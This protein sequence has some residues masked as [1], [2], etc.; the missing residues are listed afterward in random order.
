M[1]EPMQAP[2]AHFASSWHLSV[3]VQGVSLASF[4]NVH[5]PVFASHS[6]TL[7]TGTPPLQSLS[8]LPEQT[9]AEQV[10]AC[11]QPPPPQSPPVSG[12]S[13]QLPFAGLHAGGVWHSR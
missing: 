10:P 8:A 1:G 12:E 7:Q 2:A 9:P 4:T 11:E 13:S 3:G 5:I 6:P